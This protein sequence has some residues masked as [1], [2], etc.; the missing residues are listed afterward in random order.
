MGYRLSQWR[1]YAAAGRG[2]ALGIQWDSRAAAMF[3]TRTQ[4]AQRW[5]DGLM[6]SLLTGAVR[7]APR[8][9]VA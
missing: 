5:C 9:K 4:H 6:S 3:C 2:F 7:V 8:D 1:G